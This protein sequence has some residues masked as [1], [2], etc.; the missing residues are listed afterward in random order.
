M[1]LWFQRNIL[2][3]KMFILNVI[4]CNVYVNNSYLYNEKHNIASSKFPRPMDF[5]NI[6]DIMEFSVIDFTLDLF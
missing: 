4:K 2:T 1:I 6:L 3:L 5:T